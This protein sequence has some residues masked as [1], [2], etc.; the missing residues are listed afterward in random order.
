MGCKLKARVTDLADLSDYRRKAEK[1]LAQLQPEEKPQRLSSWFGCDAPNLAAIY[2]E[3]EIRH[4][5][6]Q[7]SCQGQRR[8]LYTVR[9]DTFG[10]Q[11]MRLAEAVAK[12]L[13]ER[14]DSIAE[15]LA[16]EYWTPSLEL[17]WKFWE[18]IGEEMEVVAQE[19]WPDLIACYAAFETY[20]QD[21]DTLKRFL[22]TLES[23]ADS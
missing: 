1:L 14:E 10:K 2:L 9:M 23:S 8:Y 7:A 13:S 12:K 4:G 5:P 21:G 19:P 20:R 22:K 3:G 18:Y 17:K 15:T 6:N 16:T 11:P